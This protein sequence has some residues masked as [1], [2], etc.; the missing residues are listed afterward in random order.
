MPV[1]EAL[2]RIRALRAG[3]HGVL[4]EAWLNLETGRLHAMKGEVERAQ[5]LWS[6]ARQVYVDAGL[7]LSAGSFAQGGAEIAFRAGDVQVEEARLREGLE[8]LE[9]I[10]ELAFYSTQALML[11]ECLYRAGAD[12]GEI[13]ALCAKAR[14]MTAADD[15]ANF[16][17]LDMV[18]GLLHARHGEYQEAEEGSR[19]AVA[20]ADTTDFHSARSRS[21]V[22]LAE[23]LALSGRGEEAA[24]VAA[25]AVEIFEAKGDITAAARFRSRLSSLGV[26]AD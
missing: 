20:V 8:V 21:R 5:E 1:D 12:D 15:L 22:Y 16:V 17:W 19:R 6:D 24:E 10:G 13:E 4:P 26:E 2:E 11:A 3:E 18:S 23:V 9:R 14:E 7:L 25:E